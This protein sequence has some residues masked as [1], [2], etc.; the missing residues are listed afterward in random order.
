MG[1]TPNANLGDGSNVDPIIPDGIQEP[2]ASLPSSEP[3]LS[4]DNTPE[5]EG[6]A[7]DQPE[8]GADVAGADGG[9]E[10]GRVIPK[11]IRAMKEA[12]PEGYKAA[13]SSF[14][15]L[16]ERETIHPTVQAARDEH[17]LVESV[18]GRDGLTRLQE[19]A[20]F[21][22]DAANQFVKGDPAFVKDL[23]EED[24]IAA[25]LHVS[26]MLEEFKSRDLAGYN[27][28]IAR[29]WANDFKQLNFAP[30][31][32]DLAAAIRSGDKD[33]ASAIA[34]SIQD[35]HD[36]IVNVS[37]QAEDPRVKT[38]LAE[39]SKR[40]ETQEK[41][42][43]DAFLTTYR[44]DAANAVI[45][46]G[47]KVF[48]S[49]F[50]GRN[51]DKDD[52]NDLLRESFAIANRAVTADAAFIEQRDKHLARGD[53][54]SAMKI[55]KARFAQEMS[56]A[57]KRVARRYGLISGQTQKPNQPAKPNN[58]QQQPNQPVQGFTAV[59]VRPEPEAIDR[60]RTT[61]DMIMEGRAILSDGRKVD[62]SKLKRASA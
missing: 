61:P 44:T 54:V 34:K 1:N 35:W 53:S 20:V 42:D 7:E 14:F 36:S 31:L 10:D 25:A 52:R 27:S 12:D 38:L 56:L 33:N 29:I 24:P 19:D 57:V 23:W 16:K 62:W 55:T 15:S 32:Q 43:Q 4:A 8:A 18:G 11:W 6:G 5:P 9:K 2:D 46:D 41:A 26:P 28:T 21:F 30:A 51:I 60:R 48:D 13:K 58:G 17:D 22:K 45:E 49:F 3:D 37:N 47:S 59:T 40:H 50:R 39:R